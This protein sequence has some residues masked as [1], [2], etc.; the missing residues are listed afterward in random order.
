VH[1]DQEFNFAVNVGHD[2]QREGSG[3]SIEIQIELP[4]AL[5]NKLQRRNRPQQGYL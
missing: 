2:G 3:L 5:Q 4:L 1:I